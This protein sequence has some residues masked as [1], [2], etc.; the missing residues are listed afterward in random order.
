ML[1]SVSS[2]QKVPNGDKQNIC[3]W[4][5]VAVTHRLCIHLAL[6]AWTHTGGEGVGAEERRT[7]RKRGNE[8]RKK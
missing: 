5:G 6:A 8:I 1:L 3:V 7:W 4:F 2:E